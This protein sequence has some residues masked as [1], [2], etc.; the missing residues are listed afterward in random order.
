MKANPPSETMFRDLRDHRRRRSP[1]HRRQ[2]MSLVVGGKTPIMDLAEL[3]AMSFSLVLY[4]NVAL[5][6]AVHGMQAALGAVKRDN[7]L[8]ESGRVAS[9]AERQRLVRKDEF[10]AMEQRYASGAGSAGKR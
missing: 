7:R 6:G 3:D 9:F 8:E 4:A 1:D 10:D 5:Q 2:S